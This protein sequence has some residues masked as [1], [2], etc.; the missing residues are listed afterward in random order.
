MIF[1][2]GKFNN[3]FSFALQYYYAVIKLINGKI[4]K[5]K[6][7]HFEGIICSQIRNNNMQ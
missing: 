2:V 3:V 1:I 6:I 7:K 4:L 5:I